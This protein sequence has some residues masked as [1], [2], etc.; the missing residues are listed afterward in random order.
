MERQNGT[1]ENAI[2]IC[3][4]Y[5]SHHLDLLTKIIA[6]L[7]CLKL[8][9]WVGHCLLAHDAEIHRD[10]AKFYALTPLHGCRL[11]CAWLL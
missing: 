2:Y 5:G 10:G 8:S 7:R 4:L 9:N 11:F 1:Q 6:T 3:P